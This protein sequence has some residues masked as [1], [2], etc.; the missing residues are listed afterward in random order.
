MPIQRPTVVIYNHESSLRRVNFA[1]SVN[2]LLLATVR[3]R[4]KIE[5]VCVCVG[6][7]WVYDRHTCRLVINEDNNGLTE[8]GGCH[9]LASSSLRVCALQLG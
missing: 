4:K 2:S 9:L 7:T 3:T 8:D 6:G 1:R 5:I